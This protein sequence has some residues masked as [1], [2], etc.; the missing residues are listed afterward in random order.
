MEANTETRMKRLWDN[1]REI[2]EVQKS[3]RIKLVIAAGIRDG[4]KYINIREFY[5]R[6]RDGVWKPGKYGITI[7]LEIPIEKGTK[8]IKPYEEFT[9]LIILAAEALA[10]MDL[11]DEEHA[12]YME[13]KNK[14]GTNK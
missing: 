12:V 7:P 6:Q 9:S 5:F 11:A 4:V 13:V 8:R 2:G 14:Y 10:D 3:N 1:Y